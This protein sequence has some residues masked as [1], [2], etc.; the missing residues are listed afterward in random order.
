MFSYPLE[1]RYPVRPVPLTPK[2]DAIVVQAAGVSVALFERP[3]QLADYETFQRC[4]FAAWLHQRWP[5][6]PVLTTGG[7]SFPMSAAGK[8][9]ELLVRAGVPGS[10]IMT[11][12]LSHSTY[13]SARASAALLRQ[14]GI[15]RIALVVEAQSMPRAEACF[16]KQGFDVI[17]TPCEIRQF[18]VP[19]QDEELPTWKAVRRNEMTLHETVGLLW[20]RVKGWI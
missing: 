1:G 17:P 5:D 3:Y 15:R 12:D 13:E 16:R 6:L 9:R 20:Y 2:P 18:G 11:E 19:W 7:G 10:Q 8:M 14:K 4:E